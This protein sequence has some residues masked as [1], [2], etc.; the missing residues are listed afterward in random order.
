MSRRTDVLDTLR[1]AAGPLTINQIADSL[2]VHPN[3]VRFHLE[4]LV[5]SGQV[6]RVEPSERGPGRP[7]QLFRAV[8][9]MDPEG[10][11]QYR[12]LAEILTSGLADE[13]DPGAKA[14]ELG[15]AWGRGIKP[16]TGDPTEALVELLKELG[17]AP[18][19][20]ADNQ[21]PL[22]HCP[23]HDLAQTRSAV[24]CPIHLGLMQGALQSWRSPLS[25][26]RLD[27]F[28]EPDLCIAHLGANATAKGTNT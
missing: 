25:V 6:Q 21:I 24:V 2:G 19:A 22:R 5:Q 1:G 8:Q 3:T 17:F 12:M 27:P 4:S 10:P 15:R 20:P 23:F 28:V 7:P 9:Q 11:T 13:P 18:G 14:L 26:E 16:T